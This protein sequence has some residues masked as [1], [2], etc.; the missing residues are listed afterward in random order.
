[1]RSCVVLLCGVRA[2]S[3]WSAN[4]VLQAPVAA[5]AAS[6]RSIEWMRTH[7]VFSATVGSTRSAVRSPSRFAEGDARWRKFQC[8]LPA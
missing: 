8:W 1:M 2:A 4:R 5:T 6:C 3:A 7:A